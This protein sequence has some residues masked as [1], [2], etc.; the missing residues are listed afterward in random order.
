MNTKTPHLL[1]IGLS[2]TGTPINGLQKA[3]MNI[4]YA[5]D[6]VY[7]G[8]PNINEVIRQ[9]ID[10]DCPEIVWMQI[11]R[12]DI[13]SLET[14]AYIKAKGCF[15]I[16][17]TGDKREQVPSWMIDSAPHL[18]LTTFSNQEDVDKCKAIGINSAFL[19]IGYDETIYTPNGP[20]VPA[21]E[22]VF[23]GN[24]N[25]KFPLSPLRVQMV[26]LLSEKYGTR[27]G[28]YG[29]GWSHYPRNVGNYMGNQAGEAQ[30]LRSAKIAINLSHFDCY[31]SDR[32]YRALGSGACVLSHR[33][34]GCER[35]QNEEELVLWD[36]LAD[37]VKKI[38]RYLEDEDERK[39]VA[40]NGNQVALNNYTFQHMAENIKELYLN[41]K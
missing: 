24:N 6:E 17:W 12:R 28:V 13:V 35:F 38:D 20:K 11:Q 34:G 14:L 32:L 2:A 1:H 30:L 23:L 26:N 39:R 4:G 8:T 29:S 16:N 5:Y 9:K 33:F 41:F 3:L 27:F 10:K 19:E 22:I 36:D 18:S 40:F 7:T 25:G 21:P 37:L 31:S 15:I